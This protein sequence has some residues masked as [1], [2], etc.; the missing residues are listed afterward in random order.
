MAEINVY[1][2]HAILGRIRED[3]SARNFRVSI[4]GD[5]EMVEENIIL[6]EVLEAIET[7]VVLENYPEHKRG[8]CCLLYGN[9]RAGRPVHVVCTSSLVLLV[10]ITVYEPKPPKWVTPTQRGGKE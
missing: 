6:A 9:T 7:A 2:E 5:Q 3:A 4:H 10:M 8:P 1:D